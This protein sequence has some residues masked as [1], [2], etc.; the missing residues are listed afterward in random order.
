[1]LAQTASV[2]AEAPLH[3]QVDVDQAT[4][5]KRMTSSN[6][7][8]LWTGCGFG[9][10]MVIGIAALGSP[11]LASPSDSPSRSTKPLQSEPF[12]AFAPALPAFGPAVLH[13]AR[14]PQRVRPSSIHLRAS[15][16][17]D[18]VYQLDKLEVPQLKAELK[19]KALSTSGKKPELVARLAKKMDEIGQT[20]MMS[21][22]RVGVKVRVVLPGSDQFQDI[23]TISH[24]EESDADKH[25][26]I[27][28][29]FDKD[30]SKL[31][32][33][34][35]DDLK[36]EGVADLG[37]RTGLKKMSQNGNVGRQR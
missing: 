19:D 5:T 13:P 17:E 30:K 27:A 10:V 2:N 26:S 33:F 36:V 20:G 25:L 32:Y 12:L 34:H 23:G 29:N 28:V 8:L 22:F 21:E 15:A 14:L 9:L 37:S 3:L 6:R 35:P 1:M 24:V 31:H 4:S 7:R 18:L 11:F 16:V